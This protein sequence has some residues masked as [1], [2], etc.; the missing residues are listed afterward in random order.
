[1]NNPYR[2]RLA[3]VIELPQLASIEQ[4]ASTLFASTDFA[5]E[6]GQETLPLK[7]L[8]KQQAEGLIWVATDQSDAPVGFAVALD[9]DKDRQQG[10]DR[11]LHLHELSVAPAHGR[12]GLGTRLVRQVVQF[13]TEAGF[14]NITLSTFRDIP[15]NA[16]FYQ[17]LGFQAMKSV[18]MKKAHRQIWQ[19]EK[20]EGFMLSERIFMRLELGP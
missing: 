16:P 10:C 13:A 12:Q 5:S 3:Q 17:K 2:I 19:R 6:I 7:V 11:T 1:M 14:Q 18:E 15:W 9:I 4:A 20:Q 8:Q